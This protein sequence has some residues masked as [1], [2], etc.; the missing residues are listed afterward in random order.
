V[1]LVDSYKVFNG[2]TPP[3]PICSQVHFLPPICYEEYKSL[4]TQEIAKMVQNRI[5]E[6]LDSLSHKR[7]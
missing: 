5:Q 3:T 4:K 7:L 1:V 6:K 2:I